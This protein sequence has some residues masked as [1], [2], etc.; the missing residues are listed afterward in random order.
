MYKKPDPKALVLWRLRLCLIA[1][2]PSFFSALFFAPGSVVWLV[3]TML[4]VIVFLAFFV[5]Y[6]PLKYRKL[7]YTVAG[8]V[9]V[10]NCGVIYTRR[11]SMLLKNIQY[12][13]LIT[14][15]LGRLFG[16]CTVFFEAAG[17][18]LHLPCVKLEDGRSLQ[19]LLIPPGEESF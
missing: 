9:L 8:E 2:V 15:P 12:V 17:G 1:L 18:R 11:K 7:S 4:W 14:L 6:Y 10:I 16:L 13:T 19:N 3:L 5:W